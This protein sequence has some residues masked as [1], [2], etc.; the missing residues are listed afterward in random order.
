MPSRR[1][2]PSCIPR[3]NLS[4][5]LRR[6]LPIAGGICLLAEAI[7][8][9][10]R[11]TPPIVN[12]P[13]GGGGGGGG[14]GIINPPIFPGLPGTSAPEPTIAVARGALIGQTLTAAIGFPPEAGTNV[15]ATYRWSI[16]GGRLLTD[17]RE[18]TV[19]FV[20]DRAGVVFLSATV[21]ANGTAYT[22]SAQVT[23]FGSD[24]AGA[25]TVPATVPAGAATFTASVPP[26][27]NADRTFRWVVSGD[28]AIA[29]GQGTANV[30]LRPGTPG[31]KVV[32]CNVT[33]QNLV[34]IPVR[35]YVVVSGTGPEVTVTVNGGSGGGTWRA[36][37]RLEVFADPPGPG[38]VFEGWTGD[39]D[40][41]DGG[42]AGLA[43]PRTSLTVPS[44]PVTL[45]ATYRA[46]ES[47]TPVVVP[48]TTGAAPAPG[49]AAGPVAS[50]QYHVPEDA[51]G[52]VFLLHDAG[53][54]AADWF[55]RPEQLLFARELAGAGFGV[56]ALDSANRTSGAW[57][58]AT[59]LAAN[60]D[61]LAH[62]AALDR[63]VAEQRITADTP[64]FF[65]GAGAG[66]DAAARLAEL[67]AGARPARPVRGA[68]LY[69]AAGSETLAATS[70]V[71]QLFAL[72]SN[73]ET[74]GAAGQAAARENMRLLSGRGVPS[75]VVVQDASPLL[76]GRLRMLAL[77]DEAF[78]AED[79]A[80]V[81]MAVKETGALDANAYV[82][83]IPTSTALAAALPAAYRS[84]ARDIADQIAV[85]GAGRAFSAES[86][87][88]V[89][90]FLQARIAGGPG[91]NPGRVVNLSMR[92]EIAYLGDSF[93]LGF[94]LTG[95]ARATVL[96]RA[97]GPGLAR[98]GVRDASPA[99][100]LELR[101]GATLV[102]A[103]EA[104]SQAANAA[105]LTAAAAATGAFP[106]PAGSLDSALLVTL[107]AGAYVA[108]VTGTNGTVGQVL[109]EVYDISRN[110]TRL[111]NLAAL[112]RLDEAGE[113][114]APGLAIAGNNPRTLLVRAVGPGLAAVGLPA[115]SLLPDPRLAVTSG[116]Q[117]IANNNNWAQAG[118]ATLTAVTALAGAFPLREANDAALVTAFAPGSYSL[119]ASAAPGAAA[120]GT[121]T[122]L[123]EVYEVP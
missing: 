48:A 67:L 12:P 96:L 75:A 82:K 60:A 23:V 70:R 85:A 77:S 115:A 58:T 118:T 59:T 119:Q 78:T 19:E 13:I 10:I 93:T 101:R 87:R 109:A 63:M 84:R 108:T 65:V 43:L 122:V 98:F 80:A 76:P 28:A 68:V 25:L 53:G 100:R 55:G 114:A 113:L 74:L 86:N 42:A 35:A 120:A 64:L 121:G 90:T 41:L 79:A 26:A 29:A 11:P 116:N 15:A 94:T 102:A 51:R 81:W 37:S 24:S 66:G 49:G 69:L 117:A 54:S 2:V 123:V 52:I 106:L 14:G 16:T 27:R 95:T 21:G 99:Q 33:L 56:A 105:Q 89:I 9:P 6:L 3:S 32:T 50:L 17:A 47:W 44:R 4:R 30:T 91:P 40:V 110:A 62:A 20:A 39:I 73:D 107:E 104:W 34:T 103:N 38:A 61:A 111:T 45:T 8:Q 88:R 97:V 46:V 31:T 112:A 92:G 36:G 83:A 57:S 7:G 18:R 72:A 1:I 71:P 5:W 22:P